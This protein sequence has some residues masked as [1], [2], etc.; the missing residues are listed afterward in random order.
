MI[1]TV[2]CP[3][4]EKIAEAEELAEKH[5][6]SITVG[7]SESISEIEFDRNVVQVLQVPTIHV[8]GVSS[9]VIH[10]GLTQSFSYICD[11]VDFKEEG[12]IP[13]ILVEFGEDFSESLRLEPKYLE[14]HIAK[15]SHRFDSLGTH[16]AS[17]FVNSEICAKDFFFEVKK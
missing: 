13:T 12:F 1:R 5:A 4:E 10:A 16:K 8:F 3:S 14:S 9:P 11:Y 7:E 17:V 6:L 15:Y 2:Y